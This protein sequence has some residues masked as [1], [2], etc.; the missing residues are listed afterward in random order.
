M[1]ENGSVDIAMIDLV[2]VGGITPWRKV[3]AMAEAFNMP[4]VSHLVPEI[5]VQL[6]AA[7]PNGLTVEY[8]P[9]SLRLWEETPVFSE[10]LLEVPDKP[11]LG[12]AF[13]QEALRKYTVD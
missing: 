8:M 5:H 3:A 1:I 6:M 13:D 2:R 7:I 10:G 11:G 12:L 9:W 4:V